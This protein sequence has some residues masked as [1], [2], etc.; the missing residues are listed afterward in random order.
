MSL[1]WIHVIVFAL[2]LTVAAP[3]VGSFDPS[4]GK[5]IDQTWK[6]GVPLG[7]IGAGK[8]EVM[9]DGHIGN[10]AINNN[11]D[12]PL[13]LVDGT[14]AAVWVKDGDKTFA[15]TLLKKSKTPLAGVKS[16]EYTGLFPRALITFVEPELPVKVELEAWSSLVPHK[17]KDSALPAAFFDYRIT[18]TTQRP[19]EASVAFCW[20]NALG[21]WRRGATEVDLRKAGV[22]PE[23][24]AIDTRRLVGISSRL[25]ET[26][27]KKAVPKDGNWPTYV[28]QHAMGAVKQKGLSITTAV[29]VDPVGKAL[30]GEFAESGEVAVASDSPDPVASANVAASKFSLK[31]G[32]SRVVRFVVSWY[33]PHHLTSTGMMYPTDEIV[34]SRE[35][36][37]LVFDGN[38]ETT[39]D[40]GRGMVPGDTFEIDL[41]SARKI[42]KVAV[43][44]GKNGKFDY[45]R[46]LRLLTSTDGNTWTWRAELSPQ[47]TVDMAKKG[48]MILE[49]APTT[50]SYIRLLHPGTDPSHWRIA[51]INAFS[52]GV[53]L[54]RE[55]WKGKTYLAK[56]T[57]KDLTE[58]VGHYYMRSFKN[59]VEVAEYAASRADSLLVETRRLSEEVAASN[60]PG[61]L[62]VKLIN[63]SFPMYNNTIL[64]KDGRFSIM[65]SPGG[66]GG[67]LGT[68]DQR[69]ASHAFTAAFFPELDKRELEMFARC[70]GLEPFTDGR[71]THFTGNIYLTIGNPNITYGV[72][73]WPDLSASFILQVL[74]LYR[75][76]GDR[77]FFDEMYPHIMWALEFLESAD[78][79]KDGIP[80]GGSTYDY[81]KLPREPFI[82]NAT[83][84]LA[85]LKAG[86]EAATIKG[87]TESAKRFQNQLEFSQKQTIKLLW[88]GE[89]FNKWR[90]TKTGQP[91]TNCFIAQMAGD[92]LSRLTGLGRVL[93]PTKI[94]STV[95]QIIARN[96][97]PF[98][99]VPPME[100][101]TAGSPGKNAGCYLLQHE[102]YIGCEA[103]YEGLTDDGLDVIK[104]VYDT[105]WGLNHNP[106]QQYLAY[107][108]PQGGEIIL[109]SYMTCPTT[110]HVISA[111]AGGSLDVDGKTLFLSPRV[112]KSLPE[113]HMPV[114]FS[115]FWGRLDY[116]PADGKLTFKVTKSFGKEPAVIK[117]VVGDP[118]SPA[119]K[120]PEPFVAKKGAVLKLSEY[121][122]R[123]AG[124][125]RR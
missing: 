102:P 84:Y 8:F 107:S 87:D 41:G 5:I 59:A 61:W 119:I 19:I 12:K 99:P 67:A 6:S 106:W 55:G 34:T 44:T 31:P 120:L 16:V 62:K 11:W 68:M 92:W 96:V 88:N 103:I 124:D 37:G 39:W 85:A 81:E 23:F 58:D 13:L 69:M 76:T 116:T 89:Y 51:E 73:N 46:G 74:K 111:L 50:A 18:N 57:Q 83:C 25:S 110:W 14:T 66:M 32:E 35:R 42:D 109:Q 91:G 27:V 20:A 93:P 80:E 112:G 7:G 82:Y 108:A 94:T 65:E 53:A 36:T 121:S 22:A 49:F 10:L 79:D 98:Y 9:T 86:I 71:I 64:T 101:D 125:Q 56:A 113:L 4:T 2:V 77:E 38:Q 28:G 45:P 95:K 117:R 100:V 40:T 3:A 90:D 70:Q 30:W 105:A 72:T 48:D 26:A 54:P 24:T 29:N 104:R 78:W 43:D 123:L 115:K 118:D 47:E 75:W 97:K 15:R 33:M 63:C 122:G 52:E 60:L 114:Y 1:T 17:I 21:F